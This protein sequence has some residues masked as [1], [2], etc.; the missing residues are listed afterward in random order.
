[1]LNVAELHQQYRDQK[2]NQAEYSEKFH[3]AVYEYL[4]PAETLKKIESAGINMLAQQEDFVPKCDKKTLLEIESD[5]WT[6]SQ[7]LRLIQDAVCAMEPNKEYKWPN[8]RYQGQSIVSHKEWTKFREQVQPR[9]VPNTFS[10]QDIYKMFICLHLS[11]IK[12]K[13]G[14]IMLKYMTQLYG[15]ATIV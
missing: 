10:I 9:I 15:G 7:T 4:I 11:M 5:L 14:T 8:Q 1:M 3:L 12:V 2:I 6:A 13:I